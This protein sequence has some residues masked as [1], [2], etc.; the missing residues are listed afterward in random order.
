M[1]QKYVTTQLLKA[2]LQN[3]RKEQKD[4]YSQLAETI[5][6]RKKVIAKW[7]AT[8]QP[9]SPEKKKDIHMELKETIARHKKIMKQWEGAFASLKNNNQLAPKKAA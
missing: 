4:I 8:L 9:A 3:P 2:S 7:E 5:A 1:K 6:E